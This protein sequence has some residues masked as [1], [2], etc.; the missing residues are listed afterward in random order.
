MTDS[1][2]GGGRSQES[3]AERYVDFEAEP[4][5]RAAEAELAAWLADDERNAAGF[6]RCE[7]AL[8]LARE[9]ESDPELGW[10]FAEVRELAEGG[11]SSPGRGPD[12]G[13]GAGRR[14]GASLRAARA[15]WPIAAG[16]AAVAVVTTLV[17]E[18]SPLDQ[19][20]PENAAA[21]SP[22]A[23]LPPPSMRAGLVGG[24]VEDAVAGG[25]RAV[26][27]GWIVVDATSVAVQPFVNLTR[28]PSDGGVIAHFDAGLAA[29]LHAGIVAELD[30]MSD[31]RV[32]NGHAVVPYAGREP[33]P[34]GG[35]RGIVRGTLR[36]EA[37]RVDVDVELV[38]AVDESVIWA[39]DASRPAAEVDAVRAEIVAGVAG[40]LVEARRG[41]PR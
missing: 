23:S 21:S 4:A 32:V 12:A 28:N 31:I 9:L 5:D 20:R 38:D 25:E 13:P 2:A 11:A 36:S 17:L 33:P 1:H 39:L 29:E 40:A 24:L 10:A 34:E 27:P 14:A 19:S 8:K 7:L 18:P 16:L 41:A 15:A 3:A 6:A 37:G 26:P 22:E 35:V 30:A